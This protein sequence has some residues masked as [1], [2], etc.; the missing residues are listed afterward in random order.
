M[1]KSSL[2]VIAIC[3][4]LFTYI[5]ASCSPA[6]NEK[7][8]EGL[9]FV[10]NGNGTCYVK[11]IGTCT[12]TDIVIPSKS[13]DGDKVTSIG[14][15]AF[16][17]NYTLTSVV[18]PDSVTEIGEAAFWDCRKL[19]KV[20]LSSSLT[21]IGGS[22]FYWCD[23]LTSVKIPDS[24]TNIGEGAFQN[25]GALTNITIPNGVK[26]IGDGAFSSC[27][28]LESVTVADSVTTIGFAAFHNCNRL[29]SVSF[30]NPEG[31]RCE[32]YDNEIKIPSNDLSEPATAAKH[33]TS[34]Y[35]NATWYRD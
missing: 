35:Y 23:S 9:E 14:R 33:L 30:K 15:F 2:T 4:V 21:T 28:N 16:S 32:T 19:T 5:L 27:Q 22:A 10:S 24:V 31:W 3:L 12:D 17:S 1:K 6:P 13:P 26:S 34:T 29:T 20:E 8:S 7:S 11:S 18:I 25:C